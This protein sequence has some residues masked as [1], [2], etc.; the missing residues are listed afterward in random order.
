MMI[1]DLLTLTQVAARLNISE[2]TAR[3]M[4]RAG[5]LPPA[6]YIG[7]SL[8]FQAADVDLFIRS[9]CRVAQPVC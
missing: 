7:R 9:G 5:N 8:R 4:L 3:R 2:Q 6:V 1:F